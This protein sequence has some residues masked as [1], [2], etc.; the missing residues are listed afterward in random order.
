MTNATKFL[1]MIM[2]IGVVCADVGARKLQKVSKELMD[3]KVN[4]P[5]LL[6]VPPLS[7]L[8]LQLQLPLPLSPPTTESGEAVSATKGVGVEN[9]VGIVSKDTKL[10]ITIPKTATTNGNGF[11]T[12]SASTNARGS[13]GNSSP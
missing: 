2:F 5:P 1:V 12:G 8:P 4:F 3:Q 9:G 11:G 13:I 6:M 10:G 7:P